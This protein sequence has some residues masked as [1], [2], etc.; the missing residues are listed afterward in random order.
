MVK[1][2]LAGVAEE[3][4]GAEAWGLDLEEEGWVA[5]DRAPVR[6]GSV[7]VPNAA[8]QLL[9]KSE[10]PATRYSAPSVV[11]TWSENNIR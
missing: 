7:C 5:Q 1:V 6:Q 3:W 10:Y 4:A 9:I 2:P 8:L 11:H